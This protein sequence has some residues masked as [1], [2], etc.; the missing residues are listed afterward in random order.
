MFKIAVTLL[1]TLFFNV[2][3][4]AN[5]LTCGSRPQG[6]CRR[7]QEDDCRRWNG[8][9][10]NAVGGPSWLVAGWRH[11]SLGGHSKGSMLL[12]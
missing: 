9:R 4:L 2:V 11:D 1:A 8:G 5:G 3:A 6:I 10:V 12:P 7:I